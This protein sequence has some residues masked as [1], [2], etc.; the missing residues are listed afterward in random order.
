M[1]GHFAFALEGR[2]SRMTLDP[3][4]A[5]VLELVEKAGNPTLDSLSVPEARALFEQTA[6]RLDFEPV[7]MARI[8]ALEVPVAGATIAARAYTPEGLA[9]EGA[10][11][12]AFFH[13]GGWVV[14][15]LETHDRLCRALAEKAGCKV[16]AVDYRLAPEHPFPTPV[17][18]VA[19]AFRWIAGNA[20]ALGV[21]SA[22]IAVGGDSAGGN[23][24]AVLCQSVRDA[25]DALRPCFQLLLYPATDFAGDYASRAENAE[26]YMLTEDLIGWFGGHY[27]G[28]WTKP[29]DPRLSPLRAPSL[30]DLPP[31]LVVTAGYDPLQGEGI[32]YADALKAAGVPVTFRDYPGMLHGFLNFGGAVKVAERAVGEAAADLRRAFGLR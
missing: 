31:A 5:W 4:S 15:S 16:I 17:E 29:E 18:D 28:G 2:R 11:A 13:G 32:A 21:D 8:D 19:A 10:P 30:A 14:G 24:S 25:G 22:R 23:L 9:G 1:V 20:A 12:L 26:G 7:A 27:M 6:W 3:Q